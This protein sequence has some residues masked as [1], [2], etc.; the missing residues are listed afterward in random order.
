MQKSRKNV[1]TRLFGDPAL[2]PVPAQV[3]RRAYARAYLDFIR[4]ICGKPNF[5]EEAARCLNEALSYAPLHPDDVM[6]LSEWIATESL[7]PEVKDPAKFIQDYFALVNP[8][9]EV[10]RIRRRVLAALDAALAFRHYQM[11]ELS[12]VRRYVLGAVIHDPSWLRNRGLIRIG[13][14]GLLGSN[15]VNQIRTQ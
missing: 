11:G 2:E 14:E 12:R 10:R 4:W 13:L 3:R 6:K 15:L 8:T 9:P 1:L 7:S 5:L